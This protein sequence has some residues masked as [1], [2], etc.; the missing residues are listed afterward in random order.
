MATLEPK[1]RV[2]SLSHVKTEFRYRSGI[3]ELGLG[4]FNR[5]ENA[6]YTDVDFS[7]IPPSFSREKKKTAEPL[8]EV[9]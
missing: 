5:S 1:S 2:V 4:G 7:V 8:H 3:V 6:I 9:K